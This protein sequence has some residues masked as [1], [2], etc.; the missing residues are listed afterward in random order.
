[1]SKGKKF[2][3]LS[4]MTFIGLIVIGAL[5]GHHSPADPTGPGFNGLANYPSTTANVP[6]S[7][8]GVN[9]LASQSGHLGVSINFTWVLITGFLVLFMQ[10]GFAFLVTGLTRAK[11]ASHMMM[12]NI[13]AFAVALLAYYA[14]GFAFMFGGIAPIANLGG[15]TPLSG[16]FGHGSAGV[17]GTHGF[18]L[19]SGGSYDV[20]VMVLFLFQVVFMET[21]G[22]II[23]G[24]I[25]ERISFAGFLLA[26]ISLGAIIYPIY[27]MWMW[28]GGWLA[29]LGTSLHLGHGA[30]DFAGSGVVH[31][32]G[33][34]IALAL[35]MHLGPR[36]G[37]YNK[38][39]SANAIPGHNIPFVVIGTLILVFGWMGFNPG[40]TLGATDLRIGLVAVNTLL[41]ACM[42]FVMAM[43]TTNYK[44]GKPDISMSCNGMLAGLVA[45]TA[46]CAF[47]APWAAV[48]IGAVA[49]VLVVYSVEFWDRRHIDDPCGAISVHGVNGAWGVLALGLFADGT[50]GVGW[51]GVGATATHGVQGLFYGDGG[52]LVAQVFHVVVG[53]AWAWGITWVIFAIAKR[54]MQIRVSPEVEIQGLDVPEF[55]VLAYPDFVLTST[56]AGGHAVSAP[57]SSTAPVGSGPGRPE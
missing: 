29:H 47:V 3:A 31:G 10:V 53:F 23:I 2:V 55:G 21:A 54:F 1:V 7:Q 36:I 12:M 26:E 49:G 27:G 5:W 8:A 15:V 48:I 20:G 46:P 39:G 32:T 52:Q 16:I 14:V 43:G 37:K 44:Y 45:I 41:A 30:V 50:Y 33:G 22:Y 28:G 56:H 9:E 13:A 18:F 6:V 57:S 35:A 34:W 42:G 25:A 51:N 4:L 40:S 38:D 11:N 19:Q 17:I 24:A